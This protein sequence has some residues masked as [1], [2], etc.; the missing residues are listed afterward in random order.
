MTSPSS[1]GLGLA[2]SFLGYRLLIINQKCSHFL[3]QKN[4]Y[5]LSTAR[6]APLSCAV[7]NHTWSRKLFKSSLL[8]G[9]CFLCHHRALGTL[10]H[11]LVSL[12]PSASAGN[13][14]GCPEQCLGGGGA[15]VGTP[16]LPPPPPRVGGACALPRAAGM[17]AHPEPLCP[18]AS[19]C[20][21]ATSPTWW[22]PSLWASGPATWT[23]TARA[24]GRTTTGRR[25]MGRA[26]WPSR[27]SSTALRRCG[28]RGCGG[29]GRG[30]WVAAQAGASEGARRSLPLLGQSDGGVAQGLREVAVRHRHR[31][32]SPWEPG[33]RQPGDT[34][35]EPEWGRPGRG[36]A[37]GWPRAWPATGLTS[38]LR[39]CK[40]WPGP[41]PPCAASAAQAAAAPA[42]WKAP[43]ACALPASMPSYHSELGFPGRHLAWD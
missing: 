26:A 21:T 41:Q 6:R 12:L 13:R 38:V 40:W 28:G 32:L 22:R 25:W 43:W 11:G 17:R 8:Q 34:A 10:P 9:P 39:R 15:G 23:S 36:R 7:G 4:K 19:A 27:P 14:E 24:G 42:S 35:L 1:P 18:Q 2:S 30:A 16:F 20:W 33:G 31:K 29:P 3:K 37:G 5:K